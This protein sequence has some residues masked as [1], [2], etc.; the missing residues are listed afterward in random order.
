MLQTTYLHSGWEFAEKTWP[1]GQVATVDT[2]W[3]PA[4]VPGHVHLDLIENGVI[5]HP[6]ERMNELGCQ[7]V[8]QK[9]WSYRTTFSWEPNDELPTRIL[10]FEG[11]DTICQIYLND[12]LIGEHDNM[13]VAVEIDVSDALQEGE[14]T[15]R[16][17]FESAIRVGLDRQKAYFEKDGLAADTIHFDERSFVRKAQ[18][19]YGWDWGPRLVSCGVWRPVCL[20]EFASRIV[21]VHV[22]QT[23]L[24][25]GAVQ[26]EFD[27]I[28]QGESGSLNIGGFDPNGDFIDEFID[29]EFGAPVLLESPV[30]WDPRNPQVYELQFSTID[31]TKF[32]DVGLCEV[33]L[34]QE[35][36]Q[37]GESFEFEINGQKTWA[38]GANWIPDHS[39]PSIVTKAQY[40]DRLE[41]AKDMGFNML[42]V[43]GGGLYET[44][45][46]Y[47]LC[48]E[49]GI[50][51]WQDFPFACAYYPDDE[52]WQAVIRDEA[53][54]NIKRI[55]NHACLA[56]WC[57]NNE[58]LEMHVN[59]WGGPARHPKHYYGVNHYEKVLPELVLELD[60]QT[61]YIST[62]PIGENP[63]NDGKAEKQK[64]PNSGGFGDQH[65]WDVWHGRG[66]WK[67]Y[68]D[69]TGRFSS[70]YG[71]ASSC[72]TALWSRT[73][74]DSDWDPHSKVVQWHD[75]TSKG[76]ETFHGYV[77]LH[78]PEP[79]TLE[80]WVYYSQLNQRDAL[81]FGVEHYRRSVFCRGSLI[82]Q[83]N[84]CWPV[85]S[86][87]I[88]D[89]DGEYKALGYDLRRLYAD[90]LLS[91]VR[92]GDKITVWA[93]NDGV[94]HWARKVYLSAT[95]VATGEVLA[96][97]E[98][99]AELEPN[100]R[101]P[102]LEASI[103]GLAVPD[104]L[105]AATDEDGDLMTW[106]LLA[107]P[108]AARF[109]EPETLIVS[110]N[111]EGLLMIQTSTPLVDLMLTE[112][113]S[114]GCFIDNFI[115]FT[116]PG[117]FGVRV[118]RV[119]DTIEARSLAGEH[120]IKI[121]RSPL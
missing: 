48:D 75:R 116:Q 84:D 58:N 2:G 89:S 52:A 27:V 65:C 94:E 62:S 43:W 46:F 103:H 114:P 79:V 5:A 38:R 74:D 32:V 66:D 112:D 106:Q 35:P 3:L 55:R 36:D 91:I 96:E 25:D 28:T 100:S 92:D 33:K 70:E 71:F 101:G 4:T 68:A 18:Y 8:D 7:W 98:G 85:Q 88:M 26:L 45:E 1:G 97:W 41:K 10:R 9:D 110:T 50:L 19:M 20:V 115:T 11:L 29:V 63:N 14:N 104:V 119:P 108:K 12:Q 40:R 121:T 31:D 95:N 102:V 44:D 53:A 51:V 113:G 105:L 107:E 57:G 22:K 77:K 30:L 56:L 81:R 54:S 120:R 78:Y 93:M 76:H 61:P 6:F 37:Y 117:V 42:R 73:L 111:R 72:S 59:T 99:D 13:F 83:F 60:P 67:Y 87:A 64:G 86:W 24:P 21:D 23:H 69:S 47:D 17:E 90:V 16:I 49:L 80:D 15:L 34:L 118:T 39:F 109:A 82:W